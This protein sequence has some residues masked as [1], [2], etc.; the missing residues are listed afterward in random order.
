[1]IDIPF[2]KL[3]AIGFTPALAPQLGE[4]ARQAPAGSRLMRVVETQRDWFRLHD[5]EAEYLAR[6]LPTLAN[7]LREQAAGVTIGDWVLATS[8]PGSELWI[9]AIVPPVTQIAR[10]ANDGRR[11][12]LASN[13]DTALL[14]MGLDEDFNP[15]RAERY[16]ALVRASGVAPVMVLTK[17]DLMR[18][19]RD[20]LRERLPANVP[21][22]AVDGTSPSARVELA[23]WL[24]PGQTL[25]LLGA[26]GA[27]KSTL[28][29][30]LCGEALQD[31]GG[32]R[33]GDGRG[34]HTTTARSLHRCPEG[35]CI[36]D[37][38]GLRTWSPDA[39]ARALAAAFDDV[40]ALASGCRFR[41]CSH[42][43]E[44]G[45]AVQAEVP[46]DRLL[47]YQ[48]LLRDA[49]RGELTPLERISARQKWKRLHKAGAVRAKEKRG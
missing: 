41:D 39:D 15:R 6:C 10:R 12:A 44:P 33:A 20:E 19:G 2:E 23:P 18:D 38:P 3:R 28:T 35:A 43:G 48:K 21:L 4:V 47:N 9:L 36:I 31:T 26:S 30:T 45:C 7:E 13:V 32:V 37:T 27:G 24:G 8:E 29:N 25:V 11:Q 34:M 1:M 22:V 49:K 14:V 16:I 46:A 17:A 42:Q 40:A 5:G